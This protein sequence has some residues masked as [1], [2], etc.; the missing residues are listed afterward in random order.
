MSNIF[1][2]DE[3]KSWPSF[4]LALAFA[5]GDPDQAVLRELSDFFSRV[6]EY[7][8][9]S[10]GEEGNLEESFREFEQALWGLMEELLILATAQSTR[11]RWPATPKRGDSA[12]TR[13]LT[14]LHSLVAGLDRL[15][16]HDLA[17]GSER[18]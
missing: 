11:I 9:R 5:Y 4:P 17:R 8:A 1:V 16:R 12:R 6:A 3:P 2:V 15:S 14:L 18:G 13:I 10:E 7:V